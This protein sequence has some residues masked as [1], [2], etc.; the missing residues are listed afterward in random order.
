MAVLDRLA[1]RRA[2]RPGWCRRGPARCRGWP[3]RCR[4]RGRLDPAV[5]DQPGD[6]LAPSRCGRS[7]GRRRAGPS[8]PPPGSRGSPRP[9]SRRLTAL[10]FS[11]E[12]RRAHEAE[13]AST[14][15]AARPGRRGPRRGRRRS[16][17]PTVDVGHR[18]APGRPGRR[19][20]DDAAVH[21]LV[22]HVDPAAA[23]P[24]LGALVGRAVEVLGEGPGDV[25]R[26]R[27]CASSGW[28]GEAP[29][30]TR[31][32]R[33]ASSVSASVGPDRDPGVARV[34]PP[35]R[36]SCTRGSRRSRPSG[37]CGRGS[38]AA[39]A[40]RR[41]G[42]GPRPPRRRPAAAVPAAGRA[43]LRDVILP[44]SSAGSR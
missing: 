25:G 24:D 41:C 14:R 3:G 15:A 38:W 8:C 6:V 9:R 1:A 39:A 33:I 34:D 31:S 2:R 35:R 12:T 20:D 32:P 42:R 37:G 18:H 4:R 16:A 43:T 7:P 23:E 17:C 10:G 27:C 21:L 13:Q 26:R 19:V 28:T 40:S 36:R 44:V 11:L 30:S 22:V 5:A 29:C